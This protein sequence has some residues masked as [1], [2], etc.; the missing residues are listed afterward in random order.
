LG[1]GLPRD[2]ELTVV[3]RTDQPLPFE[4]LG[5]MVQVRFGL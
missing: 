1:N 2:P 3:L 5:S 4:M